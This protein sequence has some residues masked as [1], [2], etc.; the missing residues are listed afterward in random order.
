[1]KTR[2]LLVLWTTTSSRRMAADSKCHIQVCH[3][4]TS[5][6][7][8]I[9]F[10]KCQHSSQRNSV[11]H[12]LRWKWSQRKIWIWY[13]TLMQLHSCYRILAFQCRK[14]CTAVLEIIHGFLLLLLGYNRLFLPFHLFHYLCSILSSFLFSLL[15]LQIITIPHINSS[16]PSSLPVFLCYFI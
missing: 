16:I 3:I 7:G 2:D 8:K 14:V 4:S 15:P 5:L 11:A 9:A 10:R 12:Q 1:M 13:V 6:P